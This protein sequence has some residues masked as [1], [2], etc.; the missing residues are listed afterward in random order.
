MTARKPRGPA[1]TPHPAII[2]FRVIGS[3]SRLPEPVPFPTRGAGI[4]W[5]YL[6]TR[7]EWEGLGAEDRPE[8]FV[9][10][11]PGIF[12]RACPEMLASD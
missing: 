9:E 4:S 11:R 5:H 8:M 12:W 3:R 7:S 1:P 10:V 2:P 6:L